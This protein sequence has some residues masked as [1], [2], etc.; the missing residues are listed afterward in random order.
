[1]YLIT[2]DSHFGHENIVKYERND[3]FDTVELHD[4]TILSL[5]EKWFHM[6]RSPTDTFYFLGDLCGQSLTHVESVVSRL[7]PIMRSVPCR[8]VMVRGNH[9]K[10]IKLDLLSRLFDEVQDY[11]LF[12]SNRIVLSHYPQ[13]V[14]YSQ[15]NVHGHTHGMDLYDDNHVCASI[16]VARY[17]AITQRD[18]ESTLGKVGKWNTRFLYEPWAQDYR[19]TQKHR[20]AIADS[21]GRIDLS[22]SRISYMLQNNLI[23]TSRCK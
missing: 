5:W 12:I 10:G 18:V 9:D 21:E 11:P 20:S 19:L 3:M 6:L 15:V 17:R 1:M 13:A 7:E 2:S 14:Y 23:N 16:H 4:D 22:A 8:K